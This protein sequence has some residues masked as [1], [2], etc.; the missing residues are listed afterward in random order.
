MAKKTK[1][2]ASRKPLTDEQKKVLSQ[3]ASEMW[4]RRRRKESQPDE[5]VEIVAE[6]PKKQV[7]MV[8]P[9]VSV[10][11]PDI[12]PIE[13]KSSKGCVV[14]GVYNIDKGKRGR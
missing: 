13:R 5:I 3:K 6:E 10:S 1:K 4:A 2:R 11:I 14:C 9:D 8:I 12:N 7:V